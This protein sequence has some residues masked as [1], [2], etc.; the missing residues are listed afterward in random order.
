MP[1]EATIWTWVWAIVPLLLAAIY[2]VA[3]SIADIRARRYR[4]GVAG[5]ISAIAIITA[6]I[7]THAIKIDLPVAQPSQH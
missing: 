5:I 2:C 4:W 3:R 7:P 1:Y 6:P